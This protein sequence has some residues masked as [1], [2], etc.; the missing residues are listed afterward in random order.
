[1]CIINIFENHFHIGRN[2]FDDPGLDLK[3]CFTDSSNLKHNNEI[4]LSRPLL[5]KEMKTG[6]FFWIKQIF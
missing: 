1:M 3:Y 5:D 2:I 4:C 6:P